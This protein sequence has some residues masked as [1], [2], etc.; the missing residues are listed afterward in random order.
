MQTTRLT[1]HLIK[2]FLVEQVKAK[3]VVGIYSGRF[4][5][6]GPHHK[7][8]YEWLKKKFGNAYIVTSD[9][10]GGS[11]HPMNF[12]EK[13]R[14]MMKMGIP[15][16]RIIK[17]KNPYV[18]KELTEKLPKDTAVVFAFGAKDAGRLKAVNIFRTTRRIRTIWL[19]MKSM[20]MF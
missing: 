9:I 7:K 18:A 5:P 1:E 14:H 8:T 3:K 6:F 15:S 4:Q 19:V 16:N 11:R 2:P 12:K 10:K 20:D 13:K 17:V